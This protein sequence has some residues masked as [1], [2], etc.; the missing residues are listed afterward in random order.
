MPQGVVLALKDDESISRALLRDIQLDE[1][2]YRGV[3]GLVPQTDGRDWPTVE[4]LR[5]LTSI[6]GWPRRQG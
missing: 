4:A 3:W 2:G 5:R 1:D 6:R